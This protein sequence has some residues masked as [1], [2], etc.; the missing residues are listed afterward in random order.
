MPPAAT[1]AP[2][3]AVPPDVPPP[4]GWAQAPLPHWDLRRNCSLTPRQCVLALGVLAA[5]T[6]ALALAMWGAGF[7]LVAPYALVNVAVIAVAMVQYARRARDGETLTLTPDGLEVHRRWR[8]AESVER[9]DLRWVTLDRATDAGAPIVL[10][11][12]GRVLEVGTQATPARRRAV[13]QELRVALAQ[14]RAAAAAGAAA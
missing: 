7:P 5:M 3:P 4:A 13:E 1:A 14:S 10:R 9:F 11:E 2:A 6:L 8:G 12:R